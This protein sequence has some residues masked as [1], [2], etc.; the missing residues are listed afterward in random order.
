MV[1]M[2]D[3]ERHVLQMVALASLQAMKLGLNLP[4][5]KGTYINFSAYY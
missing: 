5:V 4:K 1:T 3:R 2:S